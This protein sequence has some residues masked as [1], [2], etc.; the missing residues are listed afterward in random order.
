VR[1]SVEEV[2]PQWRSSG[3]AFISGYRQNTDS[4]RNSHQ[5]NVACGMS[6]DE[7]RRGGWQMAGSSGAWIVDLIVAMSASQLEPG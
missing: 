3:S 6:R 4:R 2:R 7:T 5:C 1:L